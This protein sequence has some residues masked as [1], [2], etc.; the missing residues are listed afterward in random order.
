MAGDAAP[1]P[2]HGD[3]HTPRAAAIAAVQHGVVSYD[4]LRQAG[5]SQSTIS[6]WLARGRL[7]RIH[8]GVYAVG[9]VA[10][11]RDGW[12]RAAGL[13]AGPA[14]AITARACC[15]IWNLLTVEHGPIDIIPGGRAGTTAPWLRVRRSPLRDDEVT[16]R[17]G[18]RVT[19]P[20][21]AIVDLADDG[22]A[23]DVGTALD[24]S[25]QLGLFDRLEFDRAIS[26]AHG[27]RGLKVLLPAIA[28]ITGDTF[29]S[30]TERRTR[31][32][33]VDT[34]LPRPVVAEIRAHLGTF[35]N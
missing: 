12:W 16:T 4:Q 11:T 21:R 28:R 34:D 1:D 9:H 13:V 7:V 25:L 8:A 30:A 20:A 6:R 14:G 17:R 18:L 3:R 19:T 26:R 32:A 5:I 27:R 2:L 35:A 10:L 22:S 33:L 24:R 29:L 23:H 31:D 15:S